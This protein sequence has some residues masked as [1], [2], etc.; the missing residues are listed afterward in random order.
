MSLCAVHTYAQQEKGFSSE[1]LGIRKESLYD[2]SS[3]TP[4]HGEPIRKEPG[5]SKRFERS[6]ENSPPLIPHDITGMLPIAQTDNLCMGCHMPAEAG[7]TGATPI[8]KS[9]FVDLNTGMELGGNLDGDRYNCMQ[10][11]V[12]QTTI[13]PPVKNLFKGEFRDK[14]GNYRSNLLDVLNEGVTTE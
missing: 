4:L 8:P 10:C 2:E 3:E 12:M 13:T 5:E 7:A 1:D 9:H 11:H 6:F 14:K